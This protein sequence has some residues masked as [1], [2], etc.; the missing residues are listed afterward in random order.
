MKLSK[1]VGTGDPKEACAKNRVIQPPLFLG[2]VL[3]SEPFFLTQGLSDLDLGNQKISLKKL[4]LVSKVLIFPMQN[5]EFQSVHVDNVNKNEL[6]K[7]VGKFCPLFFVP[8]LLSYG[9]K[10]AHL[11]SDE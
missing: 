3:Q 9:E 6:Q 11:R 2:Q 10:E 1:L 5:Q 4:R 8:P 7:S